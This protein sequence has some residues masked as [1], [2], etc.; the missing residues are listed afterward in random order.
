MNNIVKKTS[1]NCFFALCQNQEW[2]LQELTENNKIYI[3]FKCENIFCGR[4]HSRLLKNKNHSI[5][6]IMIIF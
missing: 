5:I 2:G 1:R 6:L 4:A 3:N